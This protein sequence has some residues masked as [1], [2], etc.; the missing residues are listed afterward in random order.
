MKN[1]L[2]ILCIVAGSL[3]GAQTTINVTNNYY[4]TPPTTTINGTPSVQSNQPAD[5]AQ[6]VHGWDYEGPANQSSDAY[7]NVQPNT[8]ANKGS[9]GDT[10]NIKKQVIKNGGGVARNPV[11]IPPNVGGNGFPQFGV[12]NQWNQ[13]GWNPAW[14]YTHTRNW[15]N[16]GNQWRNT[17]PWCNFGW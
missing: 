7:D 2:I 3:L 10:Y 4:G 6:E 9:T 16:Y 17:N 15:F 14:P 13:F 11:F 12:W 5:D 8:G 1:I